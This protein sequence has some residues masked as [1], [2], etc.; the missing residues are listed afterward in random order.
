MNILLISYY[1]GDTASG[2]ITQRVSEEL[3]LK[4]N[5]VFV[6]T[7][8][9]SIEC[10]YLYK[11]PNIFPDSGFVSRALRKF[12]RMLTKDTL[13]YQFIWRYRAFRQSC[14][15]MKANCIDWIYCRTSPI[16]AF[17]VG[18]RLKKKYGVKEL[19]HFTDPVPSEFS[20]YN[21]LILNKEVFCFA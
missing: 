13:E 8:D 4:G 20:T 9:S 1:Y 19:L 15:I 18:D 7:G 2:I 10:D 3:V 5:R 14:Q 12:Y 16:D 6:V 21:N 11:C 17:Q